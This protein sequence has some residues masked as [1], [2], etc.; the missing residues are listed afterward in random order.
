MSEKVIDIGEDRRRMEVRLG[1][2]LQ[3]KRQ[4]T[5]PIVALVVSLLFGLLSIRDAQDNKW[6]PERLPLVSL[7]D[8]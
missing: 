7:I 3:A 2:E 5:V 4:R 8:H 1:Q 6:C